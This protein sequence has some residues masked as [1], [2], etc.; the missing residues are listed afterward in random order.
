MSKRK[1]ID[2]AMA[3]EVAAAVS[4]A[5][6]FTANLFL[7][8][9]QYARHDLK[10]LDYARQAGALLED[11]HRN[12]RKAMIY[13][14]TRD[15]RSVFIPATFNPGEASMIALNAQHPHAHKPRP[16][17]PTPALDVPADLSSPAFLVRKAPKDMTPEERKAADALRKRNERAAAKLAAEAA[18]KPTPAP[19]PERPKAASP[20]LGKPLKPAD[21]HRYDWHAAEAKAAKG[22]VP[23]APDFSANTHRYKRPI[24]EAVAKAARAHDLKA[25]E[26]IKVKGTSTS[27]RA[28]KRYQALCIKALKVKS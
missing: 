15:G 17:T 2:E 1:D 10:S 7:G 23:A 13:A 25:L 12:H 4:S 9:G 24:M 5:D 26:A 3:A 27:P 8:T 16:I 14:V 18:A 21:Y 22:I 19:K 20:V 11:M 6:Y 28:I